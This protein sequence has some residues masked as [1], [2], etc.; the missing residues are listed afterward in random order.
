MKI[1]TKTGD[2][3]ETG[4]FAGPRVWKDDIRIEA[5]GS[6]D[7]LNAVLGWARAESPP[8]E[9]DRR[10][11]NIQH[12]LFALGAELATPNPSKHGTEMIRDA[13]VTWLEQAIDAC[14]A[15]LKPLTQFILP[16]GSKIAAALH[17]ARSVCRRA[18]R[19]VVTLHRTAGSGVSDR[20]IRYLN[21]LGD[22]LFVLARFANHLANR[23]D[24][25]W[26]KPAGL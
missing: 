10:L 2:A 3:G 5:C 23:E 17:V 11:A 4:V 16:G 18:E 19:H 12:Q 24:V 7:E 25:P 14:E 6:V 26:I 13:D 1:Y 21:R 8:E 15:S 9:I 20:T 22:F